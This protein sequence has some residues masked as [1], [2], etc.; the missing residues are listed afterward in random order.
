[1]KKHEN[2]KAV[3]EMFTNSIQKSQKIENVEEPK[4]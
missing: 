4:R 1:M 3:L 2:P